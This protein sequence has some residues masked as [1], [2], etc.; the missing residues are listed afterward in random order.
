MRWCGNMSQY[1]MCTVCCALAQHTVQSLHSNINPVNIEINL[2]NMYSINPVF[3][4]LLVH[5]VFFTKVPVIALRGNNDCLF[6]E[7]CEM[8]KFVLCAE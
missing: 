6:E 5:R 7:S 8:H 2:K 1:G 3:T 4:L